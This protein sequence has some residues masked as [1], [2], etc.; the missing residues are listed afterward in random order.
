MWGAHD[1][2]SYHFGAYTGVTIFEDNL[3][4]KALYGASFMIYEQE[5]GKYALELGY[6]YQSHVPY[7]GI[8]LDTNI[9]RYYLHMVVDGE[10]EL[11]VTPY[12]LMGGGYEILSR[13]YEEYDKSKNQAFVDIGLGFRYRL[14]R[15]LNLTLEAKALGKVDS[16]SVDYIGKLGLDFMFGKQVKKS[17]YR[18]YGLD[19]D[20]EYKSRDHTLDE[21]ETELVAFK[22]KL[23]EHEENLAKQLATLEAKIAMHKREKKL[24]QEK[25]LYAKSSIEKMHQ[26]KIDKLQES[27]KKAQKKV[28]GLRIKDENFKEKRL[29]KEKEDRK[30]IEEKKAKVIAQK[31]AYEA[32]VRAKREKALALKKKRVLERKRQLAI[33]A[34]QEALRKREEAKRLKAE[35]E[36]KVRAKEKEKAAILA[37]KV[38]QEKT[39]RLLIRNGMAVFAD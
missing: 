4:D 7:N 6:E 19:G 14:A 25:L 28:T 39:D 1:R 34:R 12:I 30:K 11:H 29:I 24:Q 2:Q 16:E 9:E 13:I 33:K 17:P 8:R 32:K 38:Q 3:K 22:R 15:Y 35:K 5:R 31:A 36:A 27:I 10:E 37:L 21:M 18:L 26:E 20:K 23:V